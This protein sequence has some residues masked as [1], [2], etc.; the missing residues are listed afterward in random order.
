MIRDLHKEVWKS[1]RFADHVLEGQKYQV[2]NYGRL[3]KVKGGKELLFEPYKMNGYLYFKVKQ[4]TKNKFATIYVHKLVAQH[5]LEQ[6]DGEFV[7]H[8]DYNKQNNVLLNLKWAT[9][10]EKEIH[11][12]KNPIYKTRPK[13]RKVAKLTEN[14]VRLLKKILNNPNRKTRLHII[15]KQFGVTTTQLKRIKSGENWGDVPSL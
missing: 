5:F 2:S 9:R 15:A 1:V 14:K 4:K 8:L 6:N 12:F 11:Q 10:R 3:T 13:P 7:I